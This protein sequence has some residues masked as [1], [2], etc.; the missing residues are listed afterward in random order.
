[1]VNSQHVEDDDVFAALEEVIERII[2]TFRAK[3][4]LLRRLNKVIGLFSDGYK[5]FGARV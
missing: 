5:V 1:M 3:Q 4:R 2:T